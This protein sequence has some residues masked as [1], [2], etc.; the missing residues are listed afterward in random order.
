MQGHLAQ[1]NAFKA[2]CV[3]VCVCVHLKAGT[4][5]SFLFYLAHSNS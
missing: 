2:V 4:L 5:M 3:F 1:E